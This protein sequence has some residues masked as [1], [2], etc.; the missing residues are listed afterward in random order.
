M[1]EKHDSSQKAKAVQ[2]LICWT[3]E[4]EF[5]GHD[6]QVYTDGGVD[7]THSNRVVTKHDIIWLP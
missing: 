7:T 4:L 5:I 3:C 1:K 6:M 2:T